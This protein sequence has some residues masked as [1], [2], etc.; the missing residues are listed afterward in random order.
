LARYTFTSERYLEP[1]QYISWSGNP[2]KAGSGSKLT[3]VLVTED[4]ELAGIDTVHGRLDFIQLVGITQTELDAVTTDPEQIPML[5]ALMKQ[6][7]PWLVT[8]T[9]RVKDYMDIK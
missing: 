6:D 7:N 2:I 9:A 4:T 8:D 5:L 1:N 3:G